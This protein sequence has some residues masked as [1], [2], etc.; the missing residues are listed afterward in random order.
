MILYAITDPSILSFETLSSDLHRIKARGA[1]MILYRDKKT[2]EYEKRA[3]RFVEAAKEAG[4]G[5]IILHNT[6]Q[7]ALR[8]GAWGVHCS[9]DAY[10]LISEGKRLGLKTVAS[11]HSLEEIK[12]AEEAGA[13]M[14]TLSP[15]FVSPG[16]GKPLGEKGF[17]RIV[18]EAKVPMIAL[19]GITDKEKI[20]RAMSCGASG[21]ASIRYFA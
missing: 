20:R 12:K 17:T 7:L 18:Q 8:L 3:E 9:S 11:T 15:L 21:I 5:K 4:F 6:P 14:V 13:D 2:A 1:S 19:G 16:K 10:G